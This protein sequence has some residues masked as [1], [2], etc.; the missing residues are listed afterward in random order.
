MNGTN[1]NNENITPFRLEAENSYSS[2]D[3]F[4]HDL[5][6]VKKKNAY[7]SKANLT[8]QSS[9]LLRR[10]FVPKTPSSMMLREK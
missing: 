4:Q 6:K 7:L 10:K 2:R 9:Q 8:S 3:N 5:P 1:L